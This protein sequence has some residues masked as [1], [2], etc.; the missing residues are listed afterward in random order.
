MIVGRRVSEGVIVKTSKA[1][2]HTS[3]I[4]VAMIYSTVSSALHIIR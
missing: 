2:V 1:V 3:A 4:S